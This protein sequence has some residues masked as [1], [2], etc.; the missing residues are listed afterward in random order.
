[1]AYYP[2]EARL[3][4]RRTPDE[5]PQHLAT[6]YPAGATALRPRKPLAPRL[7]RA[8]FYSAVA[9]AILFL[10]GAL[11]ARHWVTSALTASLPQLDGTAHLPGLSAPVTIQRDPHGVPYLHAAT[12]DDL[13]LAQ[14]YVTA[15]DRLFQMDTLRR[16][17]AGTLAEIFGSAVLPHDRLQRTLQ[18]R[19]AADRALAQLPPDQLHLL[20]VYARGVNAAIAQQRGR[21]PI[22]FRVLRYSPEPWTPRDSLLVTLAM[23]EDLTNTFPAKL[24]RESLTQRLPPDQALALTQDL[25]PVGSWRDHTPD[26]PIPDLTIPG[27][28]VEQVPLDESQASLEDKTRP[29]ARGLASEPRVGAPPTPATI[30]ASLAPLLHP[31]PRDLT[32]GSNAWAVSGAHTA[33]GKPLLSNDMHLNLTVPG[34]W[35]EADLRADE[36]HYHTTGVSIPGTP[37]ICVGHNDHIA[38]GFTNLGADVQDVYIETLRGSGAEQEFQTPEGNWQPVTHQQEVIKVA[39]ALDE[40]LDLRLTRHGDALTPI[41][42]PALTPEATQNRALSLRWTIYDPANLHFPWLAI[43]QAHDWP[44]FLAATADFGGPAQN[45]LYA[46]DAGHI[47]YHA[48]GRVPLRGPA[49]TPV[50]SNPASLP[51]DLE[52]PDNPAAPPSATSSSSPRLG[53]PPAS[54]L[55]SDLTAPRT[56]TTPQLSGPLSPVPLVPTPARE[57]SGYIPFDKLPQAFDPPTG[58]LAT[59]NARVTPDDYPY[60]VTLNWAAPYRVERITKQLAH[61]TGLTPADMLALQSDVYSD[62]DHVL[63][64]RLAYALDHTQTNKNPQA[65]DLLRSFSGR[66]TTDAPTPAIVSAVHAILWPLLL[67]PKLNGPAAPPSATVSPSV[68][69]GP[70]AARLPFPAPEDLDRIQSTYTWGEKDYALEQLLQHT[71][72]RWLP[73]GYATWDDFLA[74]ALAE[75]LREAHAPADL[76]RWSY[77]PVHTVDLESPIFERSSLLH[78]L[79]RH[80][81]GTGPHPQS[82]DSTTIKQVGGINRPFGPSERFTANLADLAS[83]TLNL[84]MGQSEDP[85]SPWFQ[86]QFP[87]W[88]RGT[89]Y[90]QNNP[91]PTHTLTLTP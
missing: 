41:L 69:V 15:G 64:E 55:P 72:A 9:L 87:A 91:T 10:A 79:Y 8:A 6:L 3:P 49:P 57:W 38:W 86:D 67:A 45:V 16:H 23:F 48:L 62:F 33:S 61:R 46:D 1:M 7:L 82:G 5:D 40:T 51:N 28:P 90:P 13:V 26:Q 76:S 70:N 34:L 11:Y 37:L 42:N 58:V 83:S 27:P 19:A 66:M 21:L 4:T 12:L 68:S 73:P 30:L 54:N 18:V 47:G 50:L 74:A 60:P 35:Y 88:L 75:G 24:A 36:A 2:D 59:A 56:P 20:E 80:P 14:G 29:G 53:P 85:A 31:T 89:T 39:H 63:A 78:R 84:P 65:A 71:P 25:Y 43:N 32:P 22:E 81:T 44:S 17:A 77:G 52:A